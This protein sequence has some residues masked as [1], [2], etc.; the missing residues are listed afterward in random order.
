MK[1]SQ[2]L[3]R[4][5]VTAAVVLLTLPSCGSSDDDRPS[6]EV[7][8]PIWESRQALIPTAEGVLNGGGDLC[9]ERLGTMR[10]QLPELRPTPTEVIDSTVE[11]WAALAETIMFECPSDPIELDDRLNT[12]HAL[13][14]EVDAGLSA[15]SG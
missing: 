8:Q 10:V 14:A 6:A 7:W 12:L 9:G 1:Q 13:A 3:R 5:S 4:M 11:E 2:A 15:S